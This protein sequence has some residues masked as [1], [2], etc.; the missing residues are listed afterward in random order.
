[1]LITHLPPERSIIMADESQ[2]KPG[3]GGTGTLPP[4]A[5]IKIDFTVEVCDQKNRNVYFTIT[6]DTL[7][8]RWTKENLVGVV[9]DERFASMPNLP[10]QCITVRGRTAVISDPL[11]LPANRRLLKK[12]VAVH[13]GAFQQTCGPVKEKT[14]QPLSDNELKNWCYWVRRLLDDEKVIVISGTVP[15]MKD[16]FRMP[17]EFRSEPNNTSA[18]PFY[19]KG[20]TEHRYVPPDHPKDELDGED[21]RVEYV[22]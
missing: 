21:D 20:R 1:M 3:Q 12:A 11:G 6:N 4:P 2:G 5:K 15:E 8:G 10:G 7:R 16:V 14:I 13:K 19:Q 22:E 9:M 17:G 18:M